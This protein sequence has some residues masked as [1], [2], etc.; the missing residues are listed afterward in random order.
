MSDAGK[1]VPGA[2]PLR[3]RRALSD[4]WDSYA[5]D[6]LP[7]GAPMV[8]RVETRRAF[9]AGAGAMFSCVAGG[10]DADHEPTD[11][12]VAYMESLHQE[13]IQFSRDIATGA[14]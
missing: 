9:Y 5:K 7:K 3:E 1:T 12:D 13:L 8:Q 4:E 2:I 14:A 10:L 6:V 11:L